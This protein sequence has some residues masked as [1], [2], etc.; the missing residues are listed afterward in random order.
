MQTEPPSPPDQDPSLVT[1]ISDLHDTIEK[2]E[3][4]LLDAKSTVLEQLQELSR[5]KSSLDQ[6]S[7]DARDWK[8]QF[9]SK[10]VALEAEERHSANLKQMLLETQK[11]LSLGQPQQD[12][13]GRS[14]P[15]DQQTLQYPT[16]RPSR[17]PKGHSGQSSPDNTGRNPG[18][19]LSPLSQPTPSGS[20]W[21]SRQQNE[22]ESSSS[23]HPFHSFPPQLLSNQARVLSWKTKQ[24]Q[25]QHLPQSP[26]ESI[27]FLIG[28]DLLKRFEPL[29]DYRQLKIWAQVRRPLPIPA[30]DRNQAQ[31]YALTRELATSTPAS[32]SSP[33]QPYLSDDEPQHCSWPFDDSVM[34]RDMFLCKLDDTNGPETP[35]PLITDGVKLNENHINDVILAI[36]A[37]KWAISGEL[38]DTLSRDDPNL[39]CVRKAFR[40]PLDSLPQATMTAEGA[41]AL[42]VRWNKR[43][44][45]HHFLVIPDLPHHVYMG[46]DILVR[47]AVQVDTIN[48]VNALSRGRRPERRRGV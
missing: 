39:Q 22:R 10:R 11:K 29:I 34:K 23:S 26:L 14:S 35:G 44:M 5:V 20:G 1:Q 8:A 13:S 33:E 42:T 28:Q 32:V 45:T 40:F 19:T 25:E 4:Q 27:P 21:E 31:C 46:S 12:Q 38:Y 2:K 18:H 16:F 47:L 24:T 36:W 30:T 17:V 15:S 7:T 9:E 3:A 41:C 48:N 43:E 6:S 37:D